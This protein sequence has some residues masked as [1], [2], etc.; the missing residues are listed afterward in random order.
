MNKLPNVT[1]QK[2]SNKEQISGADDAFKSTPQ[3]SVFYGY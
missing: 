3:C 1:N 2:H